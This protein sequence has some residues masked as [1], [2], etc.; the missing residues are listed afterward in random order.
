MGRKVIVIIEKL[1]ELP[2]LL[3]LG[4]EMGV[5]PYLG[6]RCKLTTRG[7]GKWES[8][9]GDFAKFGLTMPGEF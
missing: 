1:T 8:S 5:E 2:Q 9:G 4:E 3:K 7:S 6:L